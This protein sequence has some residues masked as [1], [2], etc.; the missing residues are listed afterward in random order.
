MI[1]AT[2]LRAGIVFVDQGQYWLVLTYEHIK[3][4]RGSGT[5]KVKVKNLVTGANVEKSFITGARVQEAA[6]DRNKVQFLYKDGSGYHFM[7]TATYEQFELPERLIAYDG[8]FLKEGLEIQ[9]FSVDGK[10]MY[11][12]LPK[13][14]DY[15][16]VQT[17]GSAKGNSVGATQKEAV[18]ENGLIVK[19]PLFINNGEVIRIDTRDASYVERAK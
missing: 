17:G 2:E 11:I 7:D 14:L 18:L 5:I 9:L 16:V 15:K 12:D 8:Q 13:I 4:G 6:L 19:V 10:P 1:N 3:M